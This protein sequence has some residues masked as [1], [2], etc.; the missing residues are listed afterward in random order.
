MA[1]LSTIGMAHTAVGCLALGGGAAVLAMKK[2][3]VTH[4]LAG[5]A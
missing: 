1:G 5:R 2:G 4:R 3:T